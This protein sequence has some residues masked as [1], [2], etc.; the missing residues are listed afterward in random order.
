[1]HNWS[2][3]FPLLLPDDLKFGIAGAFGGSKSID[4]ITE[5]ARKYPWVVVNDIDAKK[6]GRTKTLIV[7]QLGITNVSFVVNDAAHF[8]RLNNADIYIIAPNGGWINSKSFDTIAENVLGSNSTLT[9][10]SDLIGSARDFAG[11]FGVKSQF[12]ERGTRVGPRDVLLTSDFFD[13]RYELVVI[14]R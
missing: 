14:N 3:I 4:Q 7:D 9:V 10:G 6:L 12:V 1:L 5:L 8:P 2:W 11:R 13:V